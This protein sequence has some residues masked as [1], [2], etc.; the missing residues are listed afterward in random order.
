MI[1]QNLV[2]VTA[3]YQINQSLS[4]T[5]TENRLLLVVPQN[6]ARTAS[7]LII[8]GV[9]KES[10]PRK[11]VVVQFGPMDQTQT[12]LSSLEIG[13]IVTYGLYAGKEIEF[14][15]LNIENQ[16]FFILSITEIMYVEKNNQ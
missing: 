14:N 7:G 5:P 1:I 2:S 8:P 12:I 9:D 6:D 16:K 13:S 11:G 10:I 3:A 4:G 15:E